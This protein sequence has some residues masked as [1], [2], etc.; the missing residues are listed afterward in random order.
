MG[1]TSGDVSGE[2]VEIAG[3][4]ALV[5]GE[6]RCGVVLAHG[7]VF[8][9]A[10]WTPQAARIAHEGMMA[11]AVEDVAPGS[12]LAAAEYLKA[13]R[14]VK[15]VALL[16]GSAGADAIL[17]AVLREPGSADQLILLSANRPVEG[18]GA[19]P[20]LFV[21]SED[22]PVASVSRQLGRTAAGEENEVEILPGDAHA[23]HIFNTEQGEP[24]LRLILGRL[25]RFSAKP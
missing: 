12:I 7:V 5:W 4:E 19:E 14:G 11:I 6:G 3:A 25:E 24:L 15:H 2:R 21:A 9:A 20:K 13:E 17:E 16:G 8:D 1:S 23:Q 10:S 22:E 18:L